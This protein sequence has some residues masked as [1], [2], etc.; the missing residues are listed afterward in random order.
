M[1]DTE[2]PAPHTVA[3]ARVFPDPLLDPADPRLR[4]RIRQWD[5]GAADAVLLGVPC[6]DGVAL[7]KGRIGAAAG[8]A[9]IRR[10][11]DRFGTTYD[12][13]HDVDFDHL[14]LADAG[15]V[16]VA[17]GGDIAT[18]HDHIT[19]AAT[20][21]LK[22]GAIPL[23]LGGGNDAS[24]AGVRALHTLGGRVGVINI[25]A[26]F[27]VRE[28][29]D[30]RLHS[31][32]PY[33]RV[34]E[35]LG[36]PGRHLVQFAFHPHVNSRAHTQ[37]LKDRGAR[38]HSLAEVQAEG[39]GLLLAAEFDHL[40]NDPAG[41]CDHLFVSIDVDVF[42]AAFAPGVSAPGTVGLTPEQGQALAYRAGR[43]PRVRWFELMEFN[44]TYDQDDRTAR[45]CVMLLASF[46]AGVA[47]RDGV[48]G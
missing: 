5:G 22:A 31:G 4:H 24:F 1:T 9:T 2:R 25:D 40:A 33:R 45:L 3:A 27:D 29:I 14:R 42:A 38:L 48:A 19:A 20:A 17:P 44:P 21:V 34:L 30:G 13:G 41:G 26:H 6:D 47:T 32:T 7:N 28:V 18:T 11:I 37:W 35:E 8:P 15:D 43:H 39:A 12:S 23:V 10:A 36:V 16:V 46:L